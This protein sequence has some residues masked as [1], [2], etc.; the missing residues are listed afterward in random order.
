[1]TFTQDFD[2]SFD[3]VATR[4]SKWTL[5]EEAL[6]IKPDPDML[7]MWVAD[8]DFKAPDFLTDAIR[9]VANAG[10]LGY[11]AHLDSFRDA[12]QW[13]MKT[14]HNWGIETNWITPTASLG[15]AIAFAIQTWTAPGE[16][17]AFMTPVYHEFSLKVL[18][19]GRTPTQLPLA[20]TNGHFALDIDA[21]EACLTGNERMFLLCSP[22]NPGGRVWTREELQSIVAFCARHDLLLVSDEVHHDLI[23]PGFTHH[24]TAVVAPGA[25]DRM[26]IMTS[27]SKTFSIAG[28]RL[29][30]VIIP[31]DTLR[32]EFQTTV[33]NADLAPNLFGVV[34]T[35]AAYSPQ[36]AEWVDALNAYLWENAK[37]FT[38]AVNDI[39]GLTAFHLEG[40][41]LAWVDFSNT[42]M[43]TSEIWQRVTE[44]AKIAPSPGTPFGT[45]G[46][47]GLRFNLG[48]QRSVVIEATE[49]L[50][51]AFSDLQ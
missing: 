35:R 32:K 36:G 24:P 40:T 6:G 30:C 37:A 43:E 8:M 16:G 21:W 22:H 34:L 45:G 44:T 29:G 31:D 4:S 10:D 14:R 26:I 27:A 42:G 2:Q 25:L 9:D 5:V 28:T 13:W 51:L 50:A 17:V 48:T 15:N 41:Y 18:K 23:M 38:D 19:N 49:R 11:F 7:P 47:L 33:R 12:I 39:K 3:R 1:M 20:V 46:A